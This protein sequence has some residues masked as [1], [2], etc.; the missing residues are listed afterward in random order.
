MNLYTTAEQPPHCSMQ[1]VEEA[2]VDVAIAANEIVVATRAA[3]AV[4]ACQRH[5]AR[6][7]CDSVTTAAAQHDLCRDYML[8]LT[9]QH[10]LLRAVTQ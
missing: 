10:W 9:P 2:G 3:A 4:I 8:T 7:C 6:L 1:R 5:D